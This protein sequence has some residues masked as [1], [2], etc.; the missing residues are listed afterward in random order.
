[1]GLKICIAENERLSN[2]VQEYSSLQLYDFVLIEFS[3][4]YNRPFSYSR[5]EPGSSDIFI[6]FYTR[7]SIEWR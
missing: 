4:V 2:L 1:M 6:Q 3:N 7:S 5:K